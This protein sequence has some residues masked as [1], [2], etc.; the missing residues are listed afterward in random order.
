ME[1][2]RLSSILS[3]VDIGYILARQVFLEL[4]TSVVVDTVVSVGCYESTSKL[5]SGLWTTA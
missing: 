1:V 3:V 2:V 4:W 5:E